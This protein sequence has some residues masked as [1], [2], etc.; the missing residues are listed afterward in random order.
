M[1]RVLRVVFFAGVVAAA[2]A[3][4][5]SQMRQEAD[6]PF[7]QNLAFGGFWQQQ[8]RLEKGQ[9]FEIRVGLT[10]PASLPANARVEVRWEGPELGEFAF[11]GERGDLSAT[12]TADWRKALHAL[13]PDVY[14]VYRAPKSGSYRLILETVTDREQPLGEIS[15]DTGL[16][17]LSTP[18]PKQTPAVGDLAMNVALRPVEGIQWG[19]ILLETEPNSTP[20]QAIPLHFAPGDGERILRVIGG[21]DELEYYNNAASGKSPDDW[22]RIE[23]K[24]GKP[25]ILTANLQMAEPIVSARLRIYQPGVPSPEDIKPRA[26][27]DRSQFGNANP[28]PYIHPPAEVIPGPFPIYSYFEGRDINERIHQQDDNFRS[29][30]TRKMKPGGVYYLRV[31]ANQ[32]GYELELRLVDP[33][34]FT[35]VS[36]A[37]DQSIYYQLAEIDAWL[38]HRPRNIAQHR[39][40]RDGTSLFGENCMSCH[41]QSGVWGV[42]DAMRQG[43]RMPSGTVQS[44]RRLVNTMYESLRPTIELEDAASN[45]SLAPNDLG[46]APAGS[47]VAGRNIVLHERT[48]RPKKLQSYQQRRTANYVLQTADPQGINAAGKGSNFGPNVV[49]KFAAEILDRAWQD[50]GE[51]KYFFGIEEKARKIV[52]TGDNRLKVIDDLGHR[53][54]FFHRLF[55]RNYVETVERL[56]SDAQRVAEARKFQ[57]EF[58]QRVQADLK[59]LLALQHDDGSWGFDLGTT[60][61]EGKSWTRMTEPGDPAATAVS[62][63]GLQAAGYKPGDAVVA[64]AVNWLLANQ[65]EYGLW[66][67][68]AQTGFVTNAYVIRALSLLFPREKEVA[69]RSDFAPQKEEGLLQTLSRVRGLQASGNAEFADL[70]IDAAGSPHPQV[71]YYGLLGLGG[72]LAHG[73]VPTLI[74]HLDDPVKTCRE[75]AFWSLRQLLLDDTGWEPLMAAYRQGNERTRQSILQALVT[76]VD[77]LG[78]NSKADLPA[79]EDLLTSAMSDSF[80]GV[81]S[82]AYKAAWHWWVWNPPLRDGINRAWVAALSRE[83]NEALV[84]MAMRYSTAS[85][86]IVNGQIANQT[87]QDNLDQQYPELARLF[88]LLAERREK[89]TPEEGRRLDRRLTAVAASHFQER[90]NDGGPGQLGYSTPGSSELIGRAV[91]S[92]YERDA[93]G[94]IPWKKIALEGASNVNYAPL[95]QR[96]LTLLQTGDLDLVAVAARAL[97]NPQALSLPASPATLRPLLEKVERFL[98]GGRKDDAEALINFLARVKWDFSGVTET[99]EQEF[100]R[101]LIPGEEAQSGRTGPSAAL[102]S[103]LGRPAPSPAAPPDVDTARSERAALLGRI[104]GDNQTLQR[105]LVFGYVNDGAPEF[106]LPSTEWMAS[107]QEDAPTMEEAVEGAI[108]AEDLAVAELTFGR[109]TQQIVPD[110]LTSKNTILWWREG[111]PGARLTFQIEAPEAGRYDLI[112]AFLYD[113]EMGVVQFALNGQDISEPT[114]FYK[115]DL[116]ATGPASLGIHEFRKGANLLTVKMIGSNP[117]AEPNH[118]FGIDYVKVEPDQGAGSMFTKD[119]RGVDVIDPVIA[120]KD[121]IIAMFTAWFSKDTPEAKRRTAVRLANKTALRRNPEVRRVLAEYVDQEPVPDLR[122]SIQNILNS[123]DEVYGE[124]LRKFIVAQGESQS[125]EVR[126]LEPAKPFIEDILYFRDYVFAEMTKINDSDNKACIS[127]HGVPGRV[128]TLYLDPPDAAGYIPPEQLLAN[129]RKMQQRV[130]LNDVEASKLLRKPLNIQTGEEDGHQGGVRF[131][132]AEPGYQVIREW[133]LKQAKLQSDP[134]GQ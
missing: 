60:S 98:A 125:T 45:T 49:F 7:E 52:E 68:S 3:L 71:R 41:T 81:R 121:Q 107:Y 105:K 12:A 84:E 101:L 93:D 9:A 130:D 56:T 103:L 78:P 112:S 99:Q 124:Q 43:Y 94:A 38:I 74:A 44:W 119:E 28:V 91:L 64:R 21:A 40:V 96:V 27:P 69:R 79:L 77:L 73:G 8:W 104:L 22:Y 24:G 80:A 123:D 46:D 100:Y 10:Q 63:L 115:R 82:W 67:A 70:M 15:R 51:S 92:T 122:E 75:A 90:G 87:G 48:F 6:L 72:A 117:D 50:T 39:R 114:D 65:F 31:E 47:R 76:R 118:I 66:N 57:G 36:R 33:A 133:V 89:A 102:P 11:A 14:L 18:A 20:E 83:E 35:E 25:R 1:F 111:I 5:F 13:D 88:E 59:R 55:P 106:W 26:L 95:Q 131:Q 128:P 116:S 16:A 132:A 42:A 126:R 37:L 110:G 120:A 2:A 29:F 62:L 127:C 19:D 34:P 86:L 4:S 30:L 113:R 97:S 85:L 61:D 134:T 129:Y 32:P 17:P 109:T 23:Y 54:E 58:E 53:I 108:E